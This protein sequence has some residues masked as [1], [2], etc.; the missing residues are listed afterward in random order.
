MSKKTVKKQ[1]KGAVWVYLRYLLPILVVIG[2]IIAMLIPCLRY[3]TAQT[4]TNDTISGMELCRNTWDNV[5]SYLFGVAKQE[6]D[7]LMFSKVT[8]AILISCLLL[9][10]VGAVAAVWSSVGAFCYFRNPQSRGT[11]R[12]LF[13][14]LFPNRIV[15][16]LLSALTLPLLAFPRILILCYEK[17][18]HVGV[19][20][21]VTFAEPLVIGAILF[22]VTVL[23]T[24]L[25][26]P[27]ERRLGMDPFQKTKTRVVVIERE[28][29]VAETP[30]FETEAERRYYE[31]NQRAREE[32][33]ERIRK[34]LHPT[35]DED[36]KSS[37]E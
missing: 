2:M 7:T 34:L 8:L 11:G 20:L 3:T 33:A 10:L 26:I 16:V 18:L 13:V 15:T 21:N 30:V 31:M 25:T 6:A 28:E 1:Q 32:Q 12:I 24:L 36:D 35:E 27:L 9:F 5:R 23:V 4:G 14:T 19:L 22:A 37:G 17:I 29:P